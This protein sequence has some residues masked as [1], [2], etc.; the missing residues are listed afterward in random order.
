MFRQCG[1]APSMSKVLCVRS[2][3]LTVWGC[4]TRGRMPASA[5][6]SLVTFA[7]ATPAAAADCKF[8]LSCKCCSTHKVTETSRIQWLVLRFATR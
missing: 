7:A 1:C 2:G 4:R 8:E 5:S 3:R 6:L